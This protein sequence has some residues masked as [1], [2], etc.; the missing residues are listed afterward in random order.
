MLNE[1]KVISN[2]WLWLIASLQAI[3]LCPVPI[4]KLVA[5]SNR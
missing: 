1:N 2:L 5:Y 3:L 4:K